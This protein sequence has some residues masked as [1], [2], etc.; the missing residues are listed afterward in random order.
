MF[1]AP[2]RLFSTLLLGISVATPATGAPPPEQ[3]P[4]FSFDDLEEQDM[5]V[6]FSRIVG[7]NMADP[8]EYPYFVHIPRVGCGGVLI[9]SE[10]V[11]T[12]ARCGDFTGRITYVGS[13]QAGGGQRRWCA[14]YIP[15]PDYAE[16]PSDPA[17][18]KNDFA[19]CKLNEPV[20][21]DDRKVTLRLNDDSGF[22]ALEE[23][24]V[25]IGLGHTTGT[26][27]ILPEFL[28]EV[29]S[30]VIGDEVCMDLVEMGYEIDMDHYMGAGETIC[31]NSGE[32]EWKGTCQGDSGGPLLKEQIMDIGGKSVHIHV[33][34][35]SFGDLFC[36]KPPGVYARTSHGIGFI[37]QTICDDFKSPSPFCHE[38][39]VCDVNTESK[40]DIQLTTDMFPTQVSWSLNKQ[41]V[42]GSSVPLLS[43]NNYTKHFFTYGNSVCLKK[44]ASY[45]FVIDDS[46]G[47]GLT[48]AVLEGFYSVTLNG[49]EIARG[50]DF[51]FKEVVKIDVEA[52]ETPCDDDDVYKFKNMKKG[53]TCS[54]IASLQNKKRKKICNKEDP[55]NNNE[56]VSAFCPS[57]CRKECQKEKGKKLSE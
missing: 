22:P 29:T 18:S 12:A 57:S 11:L 20:Y 37:K 24:V 15:H 19:L 23:S 48:Y 42:N 53:K 52:P 36:S 26:S 38:P 41:G 16:H 8:G 14:E 56:L 7:G 3:V 28:Q 31:A 30:V 44:G 9:A 17:I 51:G 27:T 39:L 35:T 6:E 47:D 55:R 33:G 43:A 32:V 21:L 2:F 45:Q 4:S 25:A 13:F 49:N 10:W 46:A 5:D 34:V 50:R 54:D 1:V 40:L